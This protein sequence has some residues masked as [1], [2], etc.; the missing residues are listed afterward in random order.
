[1]RASLIVLGLPLLGLA[2]CSSSPGTATTGTGGAG[3]S[4]TGSGGAGP[5]GTGTASG[6]SGATGTGGGG[7]SCGN[8]AWVTYGHD[9]QRT[10]A[11][12]GCI[13]GPL[14]PLWTY[15]PAAPAG[16][17]LSRVYHP[18]ATKDTVF[19]HWS[20][21]DPPYTGT[22][23]ADRVSL[24]GMRLWTFDSGTDTDLGDWASLWNDTLALNSDG[25]YLLGQADGKSVGGTG[26]DWWGQTIPTDGALL[27]SNTSKSDG[28]GLFVGALDA[29]AA[30]VWKQNEQGTMCGQ[31]FADQTGGIALDGATLFY[32]PLYASGS[33]T[34]PTIASGVYAFDS[35]AMGKPLWSVP[36]SPAS[37]VSAGGGLVFLIEG[38]QGMMLKLLARKQGDGSV[39]WSVDLPNGAGVQ[40]PVLAGGK[41]LVATPTGVLAFGQADG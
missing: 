11:S 33:A 26:V 18:L 4:T 6:S 37:A 7:P 38:A 14:T 9:G 34:E 39:A 23:A 1:M 2:A 25:I 10:S 22:S 40:A 32:A 29:K 27:F 15:A 20:A 8:A 35:S 13:D 31:G 41:V 28:P 36:T 30:I 5:T 24:D 19:L 17:M 12:D 21:T 16:K 3:T